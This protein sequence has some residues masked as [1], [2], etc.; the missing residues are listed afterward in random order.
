MAP[1]KTVTVTVSSE[2][3]EAFEAHAHELAPARIVTKDTESNPFW[4][5]YTLDWPGAPA[6]AARVTPVWYATYQGE[7][8]TV[9][10]HHLEWYDAHGRPLPEP[11]AAHALATLD[12]SAH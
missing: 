1:S 10:L 4:W 8:A 7:Q 3:A 6:G 11:H 2:L 12:A 5:T 9:R